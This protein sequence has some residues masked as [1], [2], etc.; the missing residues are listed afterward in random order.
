[1]AARVILSLK[2]FRKLGIPIRREPIE[3]LLG[4]RSC[5]IAQ[6]TR[7]PLSGV[8]LLDYDNGCWLDTRTQFPPP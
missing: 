6:A 7:E 8:A 5:A 1:V 2:R 3:Q 4:R